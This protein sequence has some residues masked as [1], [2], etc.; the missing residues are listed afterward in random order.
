MPAE[1]FLKA[2]EQYYTGKLREHGA[3]HQ[4]ADWN[5]AASQTLRFEQLLKLCDLRQPFSINDYGCGYGALIDYMQSLGLPFRYRGFDISIAMV[6][7][8]RQRHP[9]RD[10]HSD[11]NALRPADYTVASGIFNVKF[12]VAAADWQRYVVDTLHKL[13]KLSEK[14][15]A[16]NVLTSY[17]DADRVRPDLYYADPCFFFDYTKRNFS[18]NVA[19]LHDYGLY[20][21][22]MLVRK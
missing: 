3:T 20:E 4:G 6:E 7:E 9:G 12:D 5:S 18:R 11:E 21:W 16:V 22:T 15:F 17:S 2:V 14:G 1:D 10:F 13:D 19:L 8:A